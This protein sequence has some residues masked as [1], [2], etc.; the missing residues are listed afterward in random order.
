MDLDELRRTLAA[1]R[2]GVRSGAIAGAHDVAEGGV[3][4]ALA[5]ACVAGGIGAEVSGAALAAAAGA[6]ASLD[7]E[8]PLA[9]EALFGEGVG[10]FVLSGDEAA[11][12]SLDCDVEIVGRVGG[13]ALRVG[14]EVEIPLAELTDA[15]R[16]GLA[17]YFP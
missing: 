6:V 4:V 2:D 8:P 13:D 9:T 5:E 14:E 10:A 3:A 1:V 15:Y 12:R 11:L 7:A 17:S 16:A